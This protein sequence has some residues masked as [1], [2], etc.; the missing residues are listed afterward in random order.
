[1]QVTNI[2]STYL[3][4]SK[5]ITGN[6]EPDWIGIIHPCQQLDVVSLEC[7]VAGVTGSWYKDYR[8]LYSVREIRRDTNDRPECAFV[9]TVRSI[10]TCFLRIDGASWCRSVARR[11]SVKSF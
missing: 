1:M 2:F 11:E 7:D 6:V 10:S 8:S 4:I 9:E 5:K 3:C